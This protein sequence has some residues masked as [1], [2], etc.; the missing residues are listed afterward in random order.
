MKKISIDQIKDFRSQTGVSVME[1]KKALEEARGDSKKAKEILRKLGALMLEKKQGKTAKEGRVESY[2]HLTG[3]IGATV[4]LFCETDFVAR[5]QDFKNLCHE[6]AM[7][8]AAMNP[9]D[10]KELL[11]QPYIRDITKTVGD[12]LT[13]E[14]AKL[15][16]KVEVGEFRRFE[17]TK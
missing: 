5:T 15:G 12:F 9:K 13:E 16:E 2:I 1:C 11:S 17:I 7:Q 10:T 8:V 14:V 6:L 4:V 3:K